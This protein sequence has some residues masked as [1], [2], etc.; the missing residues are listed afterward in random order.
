[1]QRVFPS[2]HYIVARFE[3]Q[4]LTEWKLGAASEEIIGV[5]IDR[6]NTLH[7]LLLHWLAVKFQYE[8]KGTKS[9]TFSFHTL[10]S[11]LSLQTYQVTRGQG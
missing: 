2:V 11:N 9:T 3:T 10:K 4:T 8:V 1:M 6:R 5:F 7:L